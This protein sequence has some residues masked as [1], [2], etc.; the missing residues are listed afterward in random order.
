MNDVRELIETREVGYFRAMPEAPRFQAEF[1]VTGPACMP[2]DRP[3]TQQTQIKFEIRLGQTAWLDTVAV[4][5]RGLVEASKQLKERFIKEISDMIYGD[6]IKRL[7]DIRTEL[8]Q[9]NY[10]SAESRLKHLLS[11]LTDVVTK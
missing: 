10:N 7:H 6:T 9:G 4:E 2:V 5:D 1:K 3:C 8:W 11:E